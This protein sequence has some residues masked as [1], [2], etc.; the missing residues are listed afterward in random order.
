M[1][2]RPLVIWIGRIGGVDLGPLEAVGE[3]RILV[4]DQLHCPGDVEH[5]A[6]GV[7]RHLLGQ[8]PLPFP[9]HRPGH[10]QH[11]SDHHQGDD[12]REDGTEVVGTGPQEAV[13]EAL[14]DEDL[15]GEADAEDEL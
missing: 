13:Q 2:S 14:G 9:Q 6:G 1:P 15:Q 10:R 5:L 12:H 4:G 3:R 7:Q 11:Q 8:D